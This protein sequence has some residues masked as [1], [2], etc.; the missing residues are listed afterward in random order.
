MAQTIQATLKVRTLKEHLC[1]GCGGRFAYVL[2]RDAGG[3][4]PDEAAATAALQ[5]NIEQ[6]IQDHVD[7]HPCPHC[8]ATQPE[9]VADVIGPRFAWAFWVGAIGLGLSLVLGGAEVVPVNVSVWIGFAVC[10]AAW[11]IDL[12]GTG[13]RPNQGSGPAAG[14]QAAEAEAAAGSLLAGPKNPGFAGDQPP[15][16]TPGGGMQLGLGTAIVAAAI[17]A[18]PNFLASIAGWPMNPG[19]YPPVFGPGDE[20]KIR[21]P[22][23]KITSVK[24]M[25][26]GSAEAVVK[27]AG[28]L[29]IPPSFHAETAA[30]TWGNR[31]TGKSVSNETQ[32]MWVDVRAPKDP[33]LVGKKVELALS[34]T[35]TY[36]F[37]VPGGFD[38]REGTF[39]HETSAVLAPVGAGATYFAMWWGGQLTAMGLLFVAWCFFGGACGTLRKHRSEARCIVPEAPAEGAEAPAAE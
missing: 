14:L 8:G 22:E 19:L 35:V 15:M 36:P 13:Y 26:R 31:I 34:T 29:G 38:E 11:G 3:Q 10:M 32:G 4:G 16:P 2:E 30:S 33:K 1:K 24:G 20:A 9:M 39:S 37:K 25:W 27:N 28:E 6:I 5:K 7:K 23:P 21:F 18:S 17:V 12:W